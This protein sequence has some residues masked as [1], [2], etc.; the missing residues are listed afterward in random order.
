MSGFKGIKNKL[1]KFAQEESGKF[2]K[3]M[4]KLNDNMLFIQRNQCEVEAYLSLIAEKLDIPK[5]KIQ[6]RINEIDSKFD[7]GVE[8]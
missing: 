8:E 2:A 6:E 7:W 3:D 1:D 5:D 4:H